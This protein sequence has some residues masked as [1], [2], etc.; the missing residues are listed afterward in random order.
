MAKSRE[1]ATHLCKR[2]AKCIQ[3]FFVNEGT[4]FD[5]SRIIHDHWH[6]FDIS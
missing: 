3:I 1:T 6:L 2:S 4:K 5:F